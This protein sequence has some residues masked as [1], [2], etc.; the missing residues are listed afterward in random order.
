MRTVKL[1][2]TIF[3][4]VVTGAALAVMLL[5][6]G[7]CGRE[8]SGIR[9]SGTVESDV[10]RVSAQ[11]A[12]NLEKVFADEGSGVMKGDLLAK[13]D[14]ATLVIRLRQAEAGVRLA[15]NQLR[16]LLKGARE[17]D[18][19]QVEANLKRAEENLKAAGDDRDRMLSLFKTGTVTQKQRDDAE[20]RY[21]LAQTEYGAAK[22][23]LR[24]IRNLARPE[25]VE[26]ARIQL[27]QAKA[28]R[29]LLAKQIEYTEIRAPKSGTIL[30]RSALSGEFVAPGSVLFTLANLEDLN[31]VIYV[32]EKVLGKVVL[33][34]EAEV[35]ADSHPGRKF[36][37]KVVHIAQEAEFTPK[38]VQ[39]T[40]ERVKL[41]YA[42]KVKVEKPDGVLK[43]GMPADAVLRID[44][45]SR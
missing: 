26:A 24:K 41:V 42:V 13:V 35:Y 15:E 22:E 14:D 12:G 4:L 31:L 32:P 10:I 29:D 23:G 40:D 2:E 43:I 39:T 33:G 38:N 19:A 3:R 25:E 16:L 28:A 17:E 18:I 44:G 7:R 1:T 34:G 21:T 6:L 36:R 45:G 8:E 37:A 27:E 30:T 20:T 9:G 5:L 11:I